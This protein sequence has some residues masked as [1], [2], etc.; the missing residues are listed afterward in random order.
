M[1]ASRLAQGCWQPAGAQGAWCKSSLTPNAVVT[2][3]VAVGAG[4]NQTVTLACATGGVSIY[5][6]LD[7]SYP[8]ALT[9][10]LYTSPVTVPTTA[11]LRATAILAGSAN[12]ILP[13]I[14]AVQTVT[15]TMS[16]A[17]VNTN[18]WTT[19]SITLACSTTGALLYYTLDGTVPSPTNGTFYTGA[20]SIPNWCQVQA[21]AYVANMTPGLVYSGNIV[22]IQTG[23]NMDVYW[24]DGAPVGNL[25]PQ[26]PAAG[27]STVI[28][29]DD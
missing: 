21:L 1:A 29:I 22:I 3:S 24:A 23:V 13:Q 2:A 9:G 27:G 4:Q 18:Y 20:V 5:Y 17:T 8:T 14:G 15:P 12:S 25:V 6:T 10:T 28:V 7:G 11:I 16:G 26:Q 19:Q